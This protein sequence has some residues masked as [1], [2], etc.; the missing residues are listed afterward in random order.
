MMK[1]DFYLQTQGKETNIIKEIELQI[2]EMW[3]K[4]SKSGNKPYI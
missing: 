3:T 4:M 1:I 2:S